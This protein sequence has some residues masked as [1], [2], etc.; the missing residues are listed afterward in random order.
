MEEQKPNIVLLCI[1]QQGLPSIKTLVEAGLIGK[2]GLNSAGE[3][4][5]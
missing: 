4:P 3:S 1:E 2:I 5:F